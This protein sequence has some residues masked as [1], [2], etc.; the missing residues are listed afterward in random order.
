MANKK[1]E[2]EKLT[3]HLQH[4]QVED[5]FE[6]GP[7][8]LC[9][10]L[11]EKDNASPDIHFFVLPITAENCAVATLQCSL[12]REALVHNVEVRIRYDLTPTE[13]GKAHRIVAVRLQLPDE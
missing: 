6:K 4:L 13:F 8:L 7:Y 12:L 2:V 5:D 9:K 1:P 3:G 10:L 11:I